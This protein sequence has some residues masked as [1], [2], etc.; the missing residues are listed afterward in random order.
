VGRSLGVEDFDAWKRVETIRKCIRG[1]VTR[2]EEATDGRKSVPIY[3]E[4]LNEGLQC[5]KGGGGRQEARLIKMGIRTDANKKPNR[6]KPRKK[7]H[8]TNK[9]TQ[10]TKTT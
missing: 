6:N 5:V 7:K 3:D 9:K 4:K 1:E 2:K 8:T 10:K